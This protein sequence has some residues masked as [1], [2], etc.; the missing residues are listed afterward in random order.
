MCV[1][2]SLVLPSLSVAKKLS[3]VIPSAL[4]TTFVV[5]AFTVVWAIGCPPVAE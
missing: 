3:V 2:T 4:M 1:P 5:E